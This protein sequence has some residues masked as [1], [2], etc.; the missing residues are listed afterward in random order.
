MGKVKLKDST[1]I[2]ILDGASEDCFKTVISTYD[3]FAT[4]RANFTQDNLSEY[5]F[6]NDADVLSGTYTNKQFKSATIA[7]DE[8]NK[9]VVTVTLKDITIEQELETLK[10]K[11]ATLEANT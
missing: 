7:E 2:T 9:I 5:S 1:E 3:D 6:Y 8:E 4:L 10:V 11:V